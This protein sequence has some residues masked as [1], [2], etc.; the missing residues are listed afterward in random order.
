VSKATRTRTVALVDT[1]W[2]GHHPVFFREM[3]SSL[4]RLGVSVIGL[5]PEPDEVRDEMIETQALC[6]RSRSVVSPMLDNDPALTALRWSRTAAALR[7]AEQRC[8]RRADL[9]FFAHLD[10]YLR[11]LPIP[12]FPGLILGRPWTGLYFRNHHLAWP[13]HSIRDRLRQAAK[14]D[15][16]LRSA[17]ALDLVGVLDERFDEELHRR[18]GRTAILFPEIAEPRAPRAVTERVSELRAR[19]HGRPIVGL[20][21]HIDKRKGLLTFLQLAR[22]CHNQPVY[23]AVVGR[24]DSRTF[25]KAEANAI[26]AARIHLADTLYL[27]PESE[28][29]P[30]GEYDAM[31]ESLTIVWAGYEDFPGSS[32][33][34]TWAARHEIP[35]LATDEGC[36]GERVRRYSLGLTFPGG[37]V[38]RAKEALET[39]LT[40]RDELKADAEFACY[41]NLN[42]RRRLDQTFG[43]ILGALGAP[44][45]GR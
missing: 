34:L 8:G 22:A 17:S 35:L 9:V 39:L 25:S 6:V 19:S 29:V 18:T 45:E 4:R 33:A 1:E 15:G 10:S 21:G 20:V 43:E 26:E 5:C 30:D 27:D 44:Q 42:S 38:Q 31:F 41:R 16:L 3:A 12:Q 11:F 14:G 2:V 24:L 28:W 36:I 13:V 40:R 23:F 7:S 32:N 37:N